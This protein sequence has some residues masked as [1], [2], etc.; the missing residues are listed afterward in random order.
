[1]NARATA[2]IDLPIFDCIAAATYRT[3]SPQRARRSLPGQTS[4]L[5]YAADANT[6]AVGPE[7]LAGAWSDDLPDHVDDRARHGADDGR[8]PV[9]LGGRTHNS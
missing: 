9:C 6:L 4:E 2:H 8:G 5:A 3:V 7:L 1:M